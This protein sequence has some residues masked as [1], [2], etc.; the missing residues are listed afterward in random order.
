VDRIGPDLFR[1]TSGG[2]AAPHLVMGDVPTL[3]DAGTAGRGVA[4]QRELEAAGI[5][6]ERI[7]LTHGDPD[8]AGG[9]D[10]LRQVTGATVYASVA[11]RPLLDRSG[12]PSL[13]PLRRR[14]MRVMFRGVPPPT[15][16]TWLD[17]PTVIAGV[18]VIPTPGHTPGHIAL[19]WQG[20]LMA[21]DA[22]V[23]GERFRESIW[24]FTIDRAT[25]RR[26]IETLVSRSPTGI[27]SS[28]GR[29]ADR[30]AERLQALVATWR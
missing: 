27:S 22:L 10:H 19:W 1:L 14:L 25:A 29:P 3:I 30:A 13:P 12:W 17:G 21:G 18:E 16:D 28:H 11:E 6:V 20:W 7:I 23:S 5:R 15:V 24:P 8:H 2:F 26:S 4:I 9:S